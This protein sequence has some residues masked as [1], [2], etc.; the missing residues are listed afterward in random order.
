MSAFHAFN[1][2]AKY[3]SDLSQGCCDDNSSPDNNIISIWDNLCSGRILDIFEAKFAATGCEIQ[4]E[5]GDDAPAVYTN[6]ITFPGAGKPTFKNMITV[7]EERNEEQR[8]VSL[9]HEKLH[10]IQ[11]DCVPELHASPYNQLTHEDVPVILSPRSWVL[12]TLLTE[13]DAYAKTAWLSGALLNKSYTD[14]FA[15]AAAAEIVTPQDVA[16]WY[17]RFPDDIGFVLGEASLVWDNKIRAKSSADEPDVRLRDHYIDRALD[18]YENSFRLKQSSSAAEPVFIDLDDAAVLALGS[19]FGPSIFG[20]H[21]PDP[22]FK[23]LNL[24]ETQQKR[25][26]ALNI[27]LGIDPAQ[28]LPSFDEALERLGSER[29]AFMA[30]SKTF[31]DRETQPSLMTVPEI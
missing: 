30:H 27:A 29:A 26:D 19:S 24:N 7:H 9:L 8:R 18:M 25:L 4:I 3:D 21:T 2:Y 15:A 10:A 31:I 5:N 6:F 11:W 14:Q 13:R 1:S 28:T 20:K 12:A 16:F 17:G 22:V 23:A